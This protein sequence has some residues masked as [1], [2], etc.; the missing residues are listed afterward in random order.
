MSPVMFQIPKF[1]PRIEHKNGINFGVV[2]EPQMIVE[3]NEP[4]LAKFHRTAASGP[5]PWVR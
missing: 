1:E 4:Q 2:A 5:K 3:E